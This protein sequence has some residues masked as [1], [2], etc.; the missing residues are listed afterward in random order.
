[1]NTQD[2]QNGTTQAKLVLDAK[3]YAIEAHES[4]NHTYD[5]KP[6]KVH[7]LMA[8]EFGVKYSHLLENLQQVSVALASL[9]AHDVIE[10]CRKTYND[11]KDKLGIDVA[12]VVYAVTNEKGRNRK[13]RANDKYYEGIRSN[14]IAVFVKICD[15]L[16]NVSY[17]KKT[18]SGMLNGYRKEYKEFKGYLWSLAYNEMFV[19]LDKLLN[20]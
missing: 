18:N 16:A 15:R 2:T 5:G 4:T 3:Q 14:H 11:V 19:E 13:E 7:L 6:Y 12:E 20:S 1:M 17:S 9:W 8:Y 10:D